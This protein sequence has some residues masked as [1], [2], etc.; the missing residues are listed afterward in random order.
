[1]TTMAFHC[2]D[3]VKRLEREL[4]ESGAAEEGEAE[5]KMKMEVLEGGPDK[6]GGGIL[7]AMAKAG[8]SRFL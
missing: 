7:V 1:M 8:A 3:G 5:A 6:T 4:E 2:C